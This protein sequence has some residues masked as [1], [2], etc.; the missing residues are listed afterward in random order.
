MTFDGRYFN[1]DGNPARRAALEERLAAVGLAGRFTRFPAAAGR[2]MSHATSTVSPGELR[3]PVSHQRC[4]A[5]AGTREVAT[6]A[7]EDDVIFT[8]WTVPILEQILAAALSEWDVLFCDIVAPIH[9]STLYGLLRLYCKAVIV[10]GAPAGTGGAQCAALSA[11]GRRAV[12]RRGLLCDQ[13]GCGAEAGG[14]DRSPSG[15]RTDRGGARR[16]HVQGRSERP[17]GARPVRGATSL[18]HG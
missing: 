10:P 1:I 4:G 15:E 17:V 16:R 7:I 12:H 6:Y 18:P 9:V 5:E 2:A 3:C 14:L 13:P 8:P 11:A